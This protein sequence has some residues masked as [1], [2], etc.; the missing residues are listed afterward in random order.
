MQYLLKKVNNIPMSSCLK[1]RSA[2]QTRVH[3]GSADTFSEDNIFVSS[4][5]FTLLDNH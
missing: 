3:L 1:H 5:K 2:K 4:P